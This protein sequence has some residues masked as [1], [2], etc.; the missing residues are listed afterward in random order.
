MNLPPR[1]QKFL[2]ENDDVTIAHVITPDGKVN[3]VL[4]PTLWGEEHAEVVSDLIDSILAN[5]ENIRI[6]E[7]NDN[8]LPF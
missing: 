3:V 6:E 4:V 8:D 1:V 7:P 5:Q 2:D